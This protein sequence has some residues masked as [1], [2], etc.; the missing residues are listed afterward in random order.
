MDT[1]IGNTG[2]LVI[3]C[4]VYLVIVIVTSRGFIAAPIRRTLGKE[5]DRLL[6]DV[7]VLMAKNQGNPVA[8]VAKESLEKTLNALKLTTPKWWRHLLWMFD[9]PLTKLYADV[10]ELNAAHRGLVDMVRDDVLDDYAAPLLLR[11]STVDP[12]AAEDLKMRLHGTTNAEGKRVIIKHVHELVHAGSES[13]LAA[14]FDGQRIALWLAIV[15]LIGVIAVGLVARDHQILLLLGALGGFLA[16]LVRINT[17]QQ[18]SSWG[19]MVLSP[20]GGALTSV[21]GLLLVRLLSDRSINLLGEVFRDNSWGNPTS[22]LAMA[23]ALLF[24]FS[25]RLFSRLAIAGTS[26]LSPARD[27]DPSPEGS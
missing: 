11:L 4:G 10:R 9:S 3:V 13:D 1:V 19:V 21:G 5:V 2:R 15:G 25:G 7:D 17:G 20:V 26:Q 8:A 6:A 27:R 18:A 16:P 14:E 24:G 22:A 23:L 12:D